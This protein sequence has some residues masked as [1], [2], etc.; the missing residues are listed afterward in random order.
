M[1]PPNETADDQ[2]ALLPSREMAIRLPVFEGPL[3]LLLFLIRKN[4]LDIYDIPIED[5]TRQYMEVLRAMEDLN[6]EVAGEF[7]VM[8]ST[9]MYI[10]SRML[11]PVS[12]Q[13]AQPEEEA[14]E[15]DPR[16]ELVEQLLEYK[17]FKDVTEQVRQLIEQQQDYLPRLYKHDEEETDPR[18]IKS[19]DR[20]ELWNVFNLVLRRLA[21]KIVQ[22][23]IHDEQVTV[24][25]RMEYILEKLEVTPEF[26]FTDL[27]EDQPK[28]SVPLVVAS[29]LAILELARLKKLFVEQEEVFGDIRCAARPEEEEPPPLPDEDEE[30]AP[31]TAATD[32]D[33]D[34]AAD[35]LEE[36]Y[37]VD[38]DAEE[39]GEDDTSDED[40][41]DA[42]WAEDIDEEDEAAEES[43]EEPEGEDEPRER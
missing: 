15:A 40:A 12:D 14:E 26:L 6:L 22:G 18:P 32:S 8:A 28:V 43:G 11:L 30:E 7:F 10:K 37:D 33:L 1:T 5:V 21:E 35:E 36:E 17:R 25:D 19:S 39:E 23:E 16:W 42:D 24:A 4:E 2:D 9:L 29:L 13:D 20:I 3:D 34:E 31:E 38:F 41:L 27:F